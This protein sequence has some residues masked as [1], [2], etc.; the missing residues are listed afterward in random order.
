MFKINR[1]QIKIITEQGNYGIDE[2]FYE[3]F[4]IKAISYGIKK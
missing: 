3:D 2:K 1:L 4:F